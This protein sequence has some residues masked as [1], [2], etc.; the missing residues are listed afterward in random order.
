MPARQPAGG[1]RR[2]GALTGLRPAHC[3]AGRC[4]SLQLCLH[5][6]L[7]QKTRL[8]ASQRRA[9]PAALPAFRAQARWRG[10]SAPFGDSRT[11]CAQAAMEEELAQLAAK[12]AELEERVCD[13]LGAVRT[14]VGK[15]QDVVLNQVCSETQAEGV[16]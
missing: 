4:S 8:Q 5:V 11:R 9:G 15:L 1:R 10:G 3:A 6:L 16:G 13:E 7:C 12:V 14:A 2:A